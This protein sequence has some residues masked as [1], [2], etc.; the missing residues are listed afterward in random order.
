LS[1][2]PPPDSGDETWV[3]HVTPES[4]QQSVVWKHPCSPVTKKFR[5]TP[6]VGKLMVTVFWDRRGPLLLDFMPRGA[7]INADS[8]CGTLA[9]LRAAIRKTAVRR[10]FRAQPAEFYNSGISKLVV[11]WDKCLNRGGDYVEK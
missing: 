9:R 7:T 1:A 5:R 6:S 2:E 11:R 8:Y 3:L 10:W 4:K